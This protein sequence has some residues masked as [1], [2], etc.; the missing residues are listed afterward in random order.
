MDY[1]KI[2]ED[3]ASR[4]P[5]DEELRFAA[6]ASIRELLEKKMELTSELTLAKK[7]LEENEEAYASVKRELEI[8]RRVHCALFPFI[9]G[10]QFVPDPEEADVMYL[11]LPDGLTLMFEKGQYVGFWDSSIKEDKE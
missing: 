4:E 7:C 8:E 1:R 9:P 3:L 5:V 6:A 11:E 2:I 10:A